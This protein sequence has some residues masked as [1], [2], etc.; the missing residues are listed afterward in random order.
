[1]SE[2]NLNQSRMH[3]ALLAEKIFPSRARHG[4]L[5]AALA[6]MLILAAVFAIQ[7]SDAPRQI[8]VGCFILL[9]LLAYL[10]WIYSLFFSSY[11]SN[12]PLPGTSEQNL[13]NFLD[14]ETL[15]IFARFKAGRSNGLSGLLLAILDHP[16]SAYIWYR[17]GISPITLKQ[18]LI[19]YAETTPQ[20]E[21]VDLAVLMQNVLSDMGKRGLSR[22]VSWREILV[23][24]SIES[25]FLRRYLFEG[26]L[27]KRDIAA[28]CEWEEELEAVQKRRH[29]FWTYDNLMRTRGIG[30]SWASGFTVTLDRYSRDITRAVLQYSFAPHLYGRQEETEA[31]ERILARS[32]ENNVVI[33]GE[34][35]V[36]KKTT[37]YALARRIMYGQTLP[38]L[39]HKRVLELDTGAILA[40]SV[41][42]HDVEKRLKLVL[43]E[44]VRA[45][46]VILLIDELHILF[47]MDAGAG[48][49]NATEIL[50]PY[51]GSNNFQLMGM[52][53][54]TGY[55]ATIARNPTL[56]RV[57]QKVEI[58]EPGKED[59]IRILHDVVPQI[60]GHNQVLILYPAVKKA[61]DL[62]DRY[63]KTVPFPEKAID[64][65]QEAA[66]YA[67]TKGKSSVVR[68]EHVEE[69]VQ[70][71]TQIPVGSIAIAERQILMDLEKI[72]HRKI[73]GQDEAVAAIA[74][75]MRRAR[76]GISSEKKP[77]GSF[78]F[79]GPTGVGKTETAKAL[80]EVYFG[81]EKR[82][83]RFDMSEFQQPD[84]IHQIIG[85]GDKGGIL[86]DQVL[87]APFSL[88]LFDEVEKAHPNIL[89][90]FLQVLDD[91][92]LTDVFGRTVDFTNTIM[93]FTSNAGAEMIRES[94]SQFREANLKER[95]LDR[96]QKDGSFRPE[97]LNRFDAVIIYRPLTVEQTEQVVELLL[98]D[99]N[100]RL[101]EKEV[102]VSVAPEVVKKIAQY[103]YD[104]QFGARPLRRAVQDKLE[105][106]VASRLLSGQ[107]KRGQIVAITSEDIT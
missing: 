96:L 42:E 68:P 49:I 2:F 90:V 77:I 50:L 9:V 97:F 60:E 98:S 13:A 85:Y 62:A 8:F 12:P 71:K 11:W 65:L 16:G 41:S 24:L 82:M 57:F 19:R 80:A 104:P 7:Y 18:D 44:A 56:L 25:E 99:F 33:V 87:N 39:A 22:Y 10:F 66:V 84:S 35:G 52:T 6:A 75:A 51:L 38:P 36:G 83:L 79:L 14:F 5:V 17:L 27:E 45:G 54:H 81:S 3:S 31:I 26:K 43:D 74:N 64:V 23:E 105:T 63:I 107:I 76:S 70:R 55:Q 61:V 95:L 91:G 34:D 101:K 20:N 89:N 4:V 88:L 94:I 58:R 47:S 53:T 15:Q 69:V 86:T 103:G 67:Q 1:M 78:L 48:M 92:R 29:E 32:G 100:R 30:K 37:A 73:V 59:V 46:N 106:L 93:I 21:I 72:L 40:G 102:Q 28:M